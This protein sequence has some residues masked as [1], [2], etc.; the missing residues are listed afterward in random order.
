MNILRLLAVLVTVSMTAPTSAQDAGSVSLRAE[1][2]H[3]RLLITATH[4]AWEQVRGFGLLVEQRKEMTEAIRAAVANATL[5]PE[6]TNTGFRLDFG[7]SGEMGQEGDGVLSL[8]L[9]SGQVA[10]ASIQVDRGEQP[11]FCLNSVIG[12][13]SS[14]TVLSRYV[15]KRE[16]ENLNTAPNSPAMTFA[17]EGD[18][19]VLTVTGAAWDDVQAITWQQMEAE[20]RTSAIRAALANGSAHLTFTADGFS[21]E[22]DDADWQ[23]GEVVLML[24]HDAV[25][26]TPILSQD[27]SSKSAGISRAP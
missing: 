27:S 13:W 14:Q 16:A 12:D 11:G 7:P 21:L 6:P 3:Q 17:L 26:S 2:D 22:M 24:D 9:A 19:L 8:T 10:S 5:R 18:H 25:L 15:A 23:A 1:F 20:D 4:V